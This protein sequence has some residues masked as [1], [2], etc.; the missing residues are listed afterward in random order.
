MTK[1]ECQAVT[2]VVFGRQMLNSTGFNKVFA[3]SELIRKGLTGELILR[4]FATIRAKFKAIFDQVT[5]N[6]SGL[7]SQSVPVLA[8][9]DPKLWAVSVCSV[10]GQRLQLGDVKTTFSVQSCFKAINYCIAL[11][12]NGYEKVN[13][14]VG[15]EPSGRHSDEL[16]LDRRTTPAVRCVAPRGAQDIQIVQTLCCAQFSARCALRGVSLCNYLRRYRTIHSSMLEQL[17]HVRWSN[18]P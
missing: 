5:E 13:R 8:R 3:G 2:P 12:E 16:V 1:R 7:P 14:H 9:Q 11:E 10:D 18:H 17:C 6:V 4:D 15:R